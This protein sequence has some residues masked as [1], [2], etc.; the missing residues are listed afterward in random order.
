M[1]KR[2]RIIAI[3]YGCLLLSLAGA[4]QAN[5]QILASAAFDPEQVEA[6]DT[7]ALRVLVAGVRVAPQRVSFAGWQN[8]LPADNILSRSEWTR[9]GNQWVQRFTLIAL[10]SANV[11]LPP[12]TVQLHLGDTVQTNPLQLSV[13]IQ[14]N[15]TELRDMDPIRDIR[16]E[17]VFWYDYWPQALGILLPLALLIWY[18]RRKRRRTQTPPPAV[19]LE[20]PPPPPHASALQKLNALEKEKPW[21]K[22]E[23]LLAYYAALSLIIREYLEARYRIPAL[24]STTR[25][26]AALLKNTGF[27]D[28]QQAA[29]DFLLQQ[30]DLVKYAE[31]QPPRTF[32]EQALEKARQLILKTS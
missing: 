22:E 19:P 29:L 4:G 18:Y 10:D 11:E 6:G 7:F 21:M 28:E 25:E 8:Y 20:P 26:I 31:M 5:A 13:S 3:L 15:A 32:H 9:S 1:D 2:Q 16:R 27:P 14:G 17:P 24:E 12:L 30:T 23:Q